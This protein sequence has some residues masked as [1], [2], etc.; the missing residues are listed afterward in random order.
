MSLNYAPQTVTAA[1]YEQIF[2]TEKNHIWFYTEVDALEHRLGYAV[3][4]DRL[5]N[6]ARVLSCPMKAAAPNWQHGRVVYAVARQYLA[7]ITVPVQMLDIGTAKGFSALIAQWA[8]DDSGREGKVTSVDVMPPD[9]RVRRNT[10]AECF[11]LKTLDEILEPWPEAKRIEFV[12][13]TGRNWLTGHTQRVHVAYVDGKHTYDEVK[14]EAALLA[15]RQQTGDVIVFDDIQVP[16]VHH[17]V[18]EM[19]GYEVEE[20]TALPKRR[21]AIARKR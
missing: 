8:L 12:Q 6:A 20:L 5:E 19:R 10:I 16:G 4:R 7:S 21:Y 15:A 17:A 9:A 11:G 1:E 13:S 2:E 14:W 18:K 3:D